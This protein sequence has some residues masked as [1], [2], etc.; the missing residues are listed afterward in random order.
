MTGAGRLT[1][2]RIVA[3]DIIRGVVMV[4]MAIDHVRVY[5]GLPPG[6]PTPGIFFTRWVTHF[7]APA[8]VFLAGTSAFL[9]GQRLQNRAGLSRFL[10]IRGAWLILLELTVI[11]LSWTFNFDFAHYLLAGVIWAIGW[12]MIVLAGLIW[13]PLPVIAGIGALVVAGHNLLDPIVANLNPDGPPP[14]WPWLVLYLGGEVQLGANGPPL[15]IL[16]VLV[17]WV[18]VMALGYAFGA[19]LGWEP[20]AASAGLLRNRLRWDRRVPGSAGIQSLWRS[21][22]LGN[23]QDARATL[24]PQHDQVSGVAPVPAHDPGS[25]D[26]RDSAARACPRAGSPI[27]LRSSEGCPSST[28][29][30]TYHSST[31]WPCWY[32]SSVSDRWIP[33]CSPTTRCG[34]RLRRMATPGVWDSFIWSSR[35][36]SRSCIS[37]AAGSPVSRPDLE[38]VGCRTCRVRRLDGQEFL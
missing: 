37:P 19:V 30:F 15:V 4:L 17:P 10:L 32:P 11:R 14:A 33:G 13:L 35:S 25:H 20:E 24:L 12:S 26:R 31:R 36:Q 7:C 2:E 27:F 1:G 8:F 28:T 9:L 5:S 3:V 23:L 38:L 16:Y 34:C 21:A 18:A 22:P 29:C 6:G